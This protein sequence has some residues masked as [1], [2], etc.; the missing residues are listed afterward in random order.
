[1]QVALGKPVY[2][3]RI[4][5]ENNIIVLDDEVGLYS[6][7]FQIR[8]I[9]LLAVE[10]IEIPLNVKIKVRYK[11]PGTNAVI[12]QTSHDEITVKLDTPKKSITPGQS[13]VFYSGENLIGGGVII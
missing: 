13:A 12:E 11:D 5:A 8:D 6:D 10:K 1:L 7:N 4:D 3:S 2:V 9:N